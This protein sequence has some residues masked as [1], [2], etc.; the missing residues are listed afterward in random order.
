MVVEIDTKKERKS[1]IELFRI[2]TMLLIVAHHYV[3]NS[4]LMDQISENPFSIRSLFY[5]LFGAWGKTGINCFVLITGYFM[6]QSQITLKK[7]VKLLA[8]I[9]FYKIIIY[10]IFVLV[11]YTD[12]SFVEFIYSIIP[13]RNIDDSFTSCF[14]LFYL[15]IPFL[16]TLI[17]NLE[18]KLHLRLVGLLIF[19][20]VILGS[21]PYITVSINYVSWFCV[22]YLIAS[23]LRLYQDSI[24]VLQKRLGLKLCMSLLVSSLSVIILAWYGEKTNTSLYYYF[25]SDSNKI[26]AVVTSI[27]AFCYFKSLK[28]KYS[29]IINTISAS[30]FG[31]LL[32]HANS[33]TMRQWLWKDVLKNTE[34]FNTPYY[35]CHAILSVLIVFAICCIIDIIRI[36]L[37]EEP[38]YR[39][40]NV[41]N[42]SF[43]RLISKYF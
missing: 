15:F 25:V 22:L 12:F 32:I 38:M 5:L 36:K 16:N 9:E 30:T 33:N 41:D 43:K 28:I 8:E 42:C 27:F 35:I 13:V 1:N 2:I 7:Y 21:I 14:L 3:V 24:C 10:F 39:V 29:K 11:G 19:I 40:W 37:V 6:C 31:V 18:R 4:G 20:Y 26:L 17:R 34:M 23:Y